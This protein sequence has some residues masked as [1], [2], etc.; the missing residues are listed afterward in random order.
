MAAPKRIL[1][2]E[3]DEDG[4]AM[5]ALALRRWNHD[6]TIAAD[7]LRALEVASVFRPEIIFLDLGL[8][9]ADGYELAA[10]LRTL[11]RMRIV[12]LSG[13][14]DDPARLE[15]AGICQHLLKPVD[16][17]MLSDAIGP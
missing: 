6:V 8:P 9:D 11:G 15:A 7:G 10:Q 12:A 4:A 5:L 14:K 13:T 17:A 2:V 3:D 16:L 1:I